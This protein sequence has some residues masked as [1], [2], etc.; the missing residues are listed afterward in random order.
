MYCTVHFTT[1]QHRWGSWRR[2]GVW[3]GEAVWTGRTRGPAGLSG[4]CRSHPRCYL[5]RHRHRPPASLPPLS[6]PDL[7]AS[8]DSFPPVTLTVSSFFKQ[9]GDKLKD[10]DLYK[11]LQV[12]ELIDYLFI[13]LLLDYLFISLLLDYLLIHIWSVVRL[14]H[15]FLART[16]R[17]RPQSWNSS[18]PS[19]GLLNWIFVWLRI[20]SS[21]A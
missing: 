5:C 3:P 4:A 14:L 15:I 17:N 10:E 7:T 11:H 13:S 6:E 16:S 8:L 19:R 1:V 21:I 12:R 20:L 9:E 2:P 18:S